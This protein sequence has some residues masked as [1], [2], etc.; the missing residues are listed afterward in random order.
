M[1]QCRQRAR[2]AAEPRELI[3]ADS[4]AVRQ[5]LD[6]H[7]A[8]ELRVARPIDLAHAA[9]ADERDDL[10]PSKADAFVEHGSIV[11]TGSDGESRRRF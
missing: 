9:A 6:A 1:I 3:A 7:V 5:D 4:R 10:V 2:L 8:A 11:S